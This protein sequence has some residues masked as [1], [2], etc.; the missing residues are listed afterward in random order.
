[1]TP[2]V[3]RR[4]TNDVNGGEDGGE[5]QGLRVGQCSALKLIESMNQ[6]RRRYWRHQDLTTS[7]AWTLECGSECLG[8]TDH[9]VSL[10]IVAQSSESSVTP[11]HLI[12]IYNT[13]RASNPVQLFIFI[14][15]QFFN[16]N[17]MP[18]LH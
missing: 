10:G 15:I 14:F 7:P 8:R 4:A 9:P 1:M 18:A 11:Q 16:Q 2:P 12:C 5:E 6:V 3:N 13:S 17:P